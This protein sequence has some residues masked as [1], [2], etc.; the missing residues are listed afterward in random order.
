MKRTESRDLNKEELM[1]ALDLIAESLKG[2]GFNVLRDY[3]IRDINGVN[4]H[5]DLLVEGEVLPAI[6]TRFAFIL[7]PRRVTLN[8]IEWYIAK[9]LVLPS[10]DKF[11]ILTFEDVDRDVITLTSKYGIQVI[12]LNDYLR[13]LHRSGSKLPLYLG[14]RLPKLPKIIIRPKLK[15]EDFIDIVHKEFRPHVFSKRKC[16]KV[17]FTLLYIPLIRVDARFTIEELE[18]SNVYLKDVTILLDGI[19]GYIL[20]SHGGSL[21]IDESIGLISDL[22]AIAY[23][24]LSI[25]SERNAIQISE[26]VAELGIEE[27]RIKSLIDMLTIRSFVDVYGDVVELRRKLLEEFKNP[28]EGIDKDLM[29]KFEEAIPKEITRKALFVFVRMPIYKVIDLVRALKGE[30]LSMSLVFYPLY[31]VFCIRDTHEERLFIYDGV[32]GYENE[33][34]ARLIDHPEVMECIS[35]SL[36]PLS[37]SVCED[38]I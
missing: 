32:S 16:S 23:D 20:T 18:K 29:I 37:K 25:L 12:N 26:L 14:L 7:Q 38:V 27:S 17:A 36:K 1:K 31:I 2:M 33:G 30:I 34:L 15:C 9:K 4:H 8:D 22:P 3:E 19:K 11:I 10:I 5:F 6:H 13:I 28:L 35:R 21:A 24:L